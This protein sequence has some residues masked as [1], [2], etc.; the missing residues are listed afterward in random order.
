MFKEGNVQH[1]Y[2]LNDGGGCECVLL[3]WHCTYWCMCAA[4]DSAEEDVPLPTTIHI[5]FSFE[6]Q[7]KHI[8]LIVILLLK[9]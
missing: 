2:A 5:C 9:N 6:I 1:Q 3:C 4:L 7:D 8:S